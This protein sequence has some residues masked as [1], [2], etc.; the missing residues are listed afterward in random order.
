[1]LNLEDLD[2][3]Q[4]PDKNPNKKNDIY[5]MDGDKL[6]SFVTLFA[7][8]FFIMLNVSSL[9]CTYT[10][11]MRLIQEIFIFPISLYMAFYF[12]ISFYTNKFTRPKMLKNGIAYPGVIVSISEYG[13]SVTAYNQYNTK[14]MRKS[15]SIKVLCSR[16]KYPYIIKG[17]DLNPK[18]CLENPYC[19][20]YFTGRKY[21]A[22]DF[23]VKD[24]YI[25]DKGFLL[26]KEMKS[27]HQN[28]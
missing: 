22:S 25:S 1:M 24:S 20:L 17:Y 16:S 23:K 9:Y 18:K 10:G 28:M 27:F 26:Y 6:T 14:K 7:T 12:F 3:I 19:T 11:E 5:K 2:E 13:D 21:I 15:Y 8:F 4:I